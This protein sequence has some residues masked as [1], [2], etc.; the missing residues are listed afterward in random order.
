MTSFAKKVFGQMIF[1]GPHLL[2]KVSNMQKKILCVKKTMPCVF[3]FKG[4][5]K[6]ESK[7]KKKS[8]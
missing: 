2:Q 3:F 5:N 4:D 6:I 1:V 7:N 8:L